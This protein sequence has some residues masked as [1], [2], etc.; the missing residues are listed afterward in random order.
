MISVCFRVKV[1]IVKDSKVMV[2][3]DD[4]ITV[5]VLLHRAWKKHPTHVDYLGLYIPNNNQYSSQAHGLIGRSPIGPK[6]YPVTVL[7]Q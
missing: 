1:S 5:M 6:C 2:T 3:V 7:L 4:K